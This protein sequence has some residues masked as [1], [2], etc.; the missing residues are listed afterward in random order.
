MGRPG[1]KGC[2]ICST[3]PVSHEEHIRHERQE[4]HE[5]HDDFVTPAAVTYFDDQ[6]PTES[7]PIEDQMSTCLFDRSMATSIRFLSPSPGLFV[8]GAKVASR[9]H[10][11]S[12]YLVFGS[13]GRDDVSTNTG[14]SFRLDLDHRAQLCRVDTLSRPDN[15]GAVKTS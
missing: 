13:S 3:V 5:R 7:V 8:N 11:V 2:R 4:R 15:T 12:I 9:W 14:A 6:G 10:H 1:R